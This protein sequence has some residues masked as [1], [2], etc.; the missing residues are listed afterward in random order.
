MTGVALHLALQVAGK[1]C[2][3]RN[4]RGQCLGGTMP[5]GRVVGA[6]WALL[7]LGACTQSFGPSSSDYGPVRAAPGEAIVVTGFDVVVGG[8]GL[9]ELGTPEAGDYRLAFHLYDP[10][11][12]SFVGAPRAFYVEQTCA[13]GST[14]QRACKAEARHVAI[15]VPPGDYVLAFVS[16]SYW[17]YIPPGVWAAGHYGA[18]G[19]TLPTV[20]ITNTNN[21][22]GSYT[23]VAGTSLAGRTAPRFHIDAGETLYVGF[24]EIESAVVERPFSISNG[25][26]D[27]GLAD[28]KVVVE[29]RPDQARAALEKA[30]LPA[31]GMVERLA[32]PP[33]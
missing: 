28:A 2:Y 11:T 29:S 31:T 1:A 5:R 7:A 22:V 10:A 23:A 12:Q 19:G 15:A 24:L 8:A 17:G 4:R 25:Q 30:G 33:P 32:A 20:E 6:L 13:G 27:W 16:K 14:G 26:R 21:V 3:V 18:R 9:G